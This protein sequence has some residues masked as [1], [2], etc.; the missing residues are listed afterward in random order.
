M[1]N[2]GVRKFFEFGQGKVLC[3]VLK[4]IDKNLSFTNFIGIIEIKFL[5]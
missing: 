4:R 2:K 1:V 3:V 5:S